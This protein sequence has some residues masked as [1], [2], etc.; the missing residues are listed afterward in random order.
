MEH[1]LPS[2]PDKF[3]GCELIFPDTVLYH[4]GKPTMLLKF[5]KQFCLTAIKASKQKKDSKHN[6]LSSENIYKQL[7]MALRERKQDRNGVF[8]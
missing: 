4:K 8:A 5:D 3:R 2:H 7:S 6:K 1:L